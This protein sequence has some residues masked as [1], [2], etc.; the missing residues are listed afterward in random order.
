MAFSYSCQS[1][2]LLPL[3]RWRLWAAACSSWS[4]TRPWSCCFLGTAGRWFPRLR[5]RRTRCREGCRRSGLRA[6]GEW[7]GRS[8]SAN[9]QRRTPGGARPPSSL[10]AGR[11]RR[12]PTTA[13]SPEGSQ[14]IRPDS[15]QFL[16]PVHSPRDLTVKIVQLG[17]SGNNDNICNKNVDYN[18]NNNDNSIDYKDCISYD[19]QVFIMTIMKFLSPVAAPGDDDS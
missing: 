5:E 15:L 18:I 3:R 8:R 7:A 14:D 17:N 6:P 12:R 13:R 2:H 9:P 10:R 19:C 4:R 11:A 1:R 16:P